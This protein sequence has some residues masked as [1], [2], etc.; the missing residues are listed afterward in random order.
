MIM[1][2]EKYAR[3]E[4]LS[5]RGFD[6]PSETVLGAER[7]EPLVIPN[8][9]VFILIKPLAMANKETSTRIMD[10]LSKYGTVENAQSRLVTDRESIENHY[11]DSAGQQYHPPIVKYLTDQ[12]ATHFVLRDTMPIGE[13]EGG[14]ANYLRSNV[15]GPSDPGLT[16]PH[17]IR[18]WPVQEGLDYKID[19]VDL[20][21][22]DRI[23]NW[24]TIMDNL[25]HCSDSTVSALNEISNWYK[26]TP[27][28]VQYYSDE[29]EAMLRETEI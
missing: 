22:E 8:D 15:I 16:E 24:T 27:E 9:L 7:R 14:F 28:V 4:E 2:M 11:S 20:P 18:N 13:R 10:E 23:N 1:P 17:H 29:F 6:T 3:T 12:R 19:V 25:V 21:E 5:P 26:D